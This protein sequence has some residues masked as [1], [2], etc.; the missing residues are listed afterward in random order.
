MSR[1]QTRSDLL[2]QIARLKAQN[3]QLHG[4]LDEIAEIVNDEEFEDLG[5]ESRKQEEFDEDEDDDA[6]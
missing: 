2:A 5:S 6:E 3:K 1:I 4:A